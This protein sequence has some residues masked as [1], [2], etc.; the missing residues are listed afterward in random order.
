MNPSS[1]FGA[2]GRATTG[3]A[4]AA[5]IGSLGSDANCSGLVF[6]E[7]FSIATSEAG[8]KGRVGASVAAGRLETMAWADIDRGGATD[9]LGNSDLKNA[10]G[11]LAISIGLASTFPSGVG[12]TVMG[13]HTEVPTP[14]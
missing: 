7:G 11:A 2:P 9:T 6:T 10:G 1:G 14:S 3:L 4:G 8:T 12:G 5:S 13:D